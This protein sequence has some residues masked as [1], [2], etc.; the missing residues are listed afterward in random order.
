MA[1]G[2]RS[3]ISL[4][5]PTQ[6]RLVSIDIF[7]IGGVDTRSFPAWSSPSLNEVGA[8]VAGAQLSPIERDDAA[9][10]FLL[11]LQHLYERNVIH[12]DIKVG[13]CVRAGI[14]TPG[15]SSNQQLFMGEE[16]GG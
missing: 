11:A 14:A 9:I 12:R 8:G 13:L 6:P 3:P 2:P 10:A 16:G 5:A 4:Y 1:K 15:A 7:V